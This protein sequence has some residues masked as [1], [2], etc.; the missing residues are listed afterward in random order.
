[1]YQERSDTPATHLPA[2]DIKA[3]ISATHICRT[4]A[5]TAIY[6]YSFFQFLCAL[7]FSYVGFVQNAAICLLVN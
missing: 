5:R 1:M 3:E 4:A 2:Q 7:F 6:S